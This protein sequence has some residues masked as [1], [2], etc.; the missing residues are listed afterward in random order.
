MTEN[1]ETQNA[2]ENDSLTEERVGKISKK[3]I[4]A[5]VFAGIFTVAA[6]LI[7]FALRFLKS[8]Y[9][10]V[11]IDQ[12][13]YQ[14][15]ASITGTNAELSGNAVFSIVGL[16][17]IV[18]AVE[19]FLW[20]I[21]SGN[22][23]AIFGKFVGYVTF[24]A[25]KVAAFFKKHVLKIA[26]AAF[27]LSFMLFAFSLDLF[28]YLFTT[29]S[30]SDFI[31]EHY[32]DPKTA[33]ITFPEE[34]RNLIYIF[35]ESMENTFSDVS[36]GGPISDNFIKELVELRDA[37]LSFSNNETNHGG[38]LSYM[39]TTWTA[40]A[41]I[42]QTAGFPVQVPLFSDEYDE[43]KSLLPGAYTIGDVLRDAGYRQVLLFGSDARFADRY[44]YFKTHGNYEILDTEALKAAGRLP[45]DYSEW[46]G[47]EDEKLFGYAKEELVKLAA[48]D[49]P[50]SL[51]MLTADSHFPSGYACELCPDKYSAQY[52]NV[53][54]CTARQIC[55]FVEWV[56]AQDFYEN[57]TIVISGDHLTMDPEFLIGVR[58]DYV[59]TVYN[60]FI[61]SAIT[62]EHTQNR[63]FGTFD[64]YPTTL[65]ALGVKIEGDRLALGTNLFSGK[66]TLTEE[67][68]YEFLDDELLKYSVFY[69][70]KLY[71]MDGIFG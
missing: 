36:A 54:S 32:V 24:A 66:K 10:H 37:N 43:G 23:K 26:S 9:D 67:Y 40:A 7:F 27:L 11:Y 53:L 50:F 65:A 19:I 70:E 56:Q 15:K 38:A 45:E 61:N 59:R 58:K 49:E 21:I 39:G 68:G 8:M 69:D 20:V 3:R 29:A 33:A 52:P 47:F 35:V 30:D 6:N 16:G 57:T 2:G 62:T 64:M 22:A 55:D 14:L 63:L 60:C 13:L 44:P 12:L 1:N 4:W 51:T 5:L 48:G 18:S 25:G 71:Q 31:E 17:L 42:T 28:A 41:L 46:W 34:K